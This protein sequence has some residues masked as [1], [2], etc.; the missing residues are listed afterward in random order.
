VVNTKYRK[1]IQALRGLSVILVILYHSF[2]KLFPGGFLGVDVFFVI[3]GFV[4]TPLI[5]NIFQSKFQLRNSLISLKYFYLNRFYRLAPALISSLIFSIILVLSFAS[6]HD[7]QRFARQGIATILLS[8]NFGAYKYSGDYFGP[9]P[10][11]LVHTWS[12]SVESQIYLVLPIIIIFLFTIFK[13]PRMIFL[14]ITALS[15]VLFLAPTLLES[16]YIRFGIY[17]SVQ[18]SFYSSVSRV[19]Q[20]TVGSLIYLLLS[21]GKELK[22][23]RIRVV[24]IT[25]VIIGFILLVNPIYLDARINTILATILAGLLVSFKQLDYLPT[26]LSNAF[27]WLGDRS[28][29]IYLVHMPLI[30]IAQY[31]LV[32]QSNPNLKTVQTI[33]AMILSV[34]IGS[35]SYEKIEQRYR[36]YFHDE[37]TGGYKP[38]TQIVSQGKKIKGGIR[39]SNRFFAKSTIFIVSMSMLV[40]MDKGSQVNYW[41]LDRT[42]ERPPPASMFDP[43]CVRDSEFGNPCI[44]EYNGADRTVLL[45]GDSHSAAL[46]QAVVDAAQNAKWNSI[47]WVQSGCRFQIRPH[48]NNKL[49]NCIK[50]NE[51]KKDYIQSNLPDLVIV[52]Q[53]I[54]NSANLGQ[55]QNSLATLRSSSEVLVIENIPVFPDGD[56]F[57]YARPLILPAYNP[58]KYFA[59]N[60]MLTDYQEASNKYRSLVE[61][62]G[63]PTMSLRNLFCNS[64]KCVRY[65]NGSWLYRDASHLSIEG[66]NLAVPLIEKFLLDFR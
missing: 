55:L 21:G 54:D 59:T 11:P 49:T 44:Y 37:N 9:N 23:K 25:I 20:F 62:V 65:L 2:S 33:A 42:T 4:V 22:V 48:V 24:N 31:Q 41:G 18:F 46:S 43:N 26:A 5:L 19:W 27:I 1:D 53:F 63:I 17:D 40:V 60:N 57:M 28:Y 61:G 12:L 56:D 64:T 32:Y 8:G 14:G 66:A 35:L 29:S 51:L 15:F 34:L 58:P 45:I 36:R 30:Y 3:S 50:Q 7:H 16:V 52:A 38:R 13:K 39:A 6:P 47:I 10:N